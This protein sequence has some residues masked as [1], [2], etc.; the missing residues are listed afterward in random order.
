VQRQEVSDFFVVTEGNIAILK[1]LEKRKEPGMSLAK[2]WYS[3]DEAASKFGVPKPLILKWVDEG[4]VRCEHQ[5]ARVVVVNGDDV[6][7]MVKEY[8]KRG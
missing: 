4:V 7:L 8:V 3:P 2:T 1:F 5:D 6:E